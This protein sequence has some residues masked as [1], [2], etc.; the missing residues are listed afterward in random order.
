MEI[1]YFFSGENHKTAKR[2]YKELFLNA[3]INEVSF[4]GTVQNS[5]PKTEKKINK[6]TVKSDLLKNYLLIKSERSTIMN[7][8]NNNYSL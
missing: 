8:S 6:Q 5:S 7:F 3:W 2:P 4:S 1:R